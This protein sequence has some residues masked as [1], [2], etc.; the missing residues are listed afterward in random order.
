MTIVGAIMCEL[1][2][3]IFGVLKSG[4]PFD[5]TMHATCAWCEFDPDHLGRAQGACSGQA[6]AAVRAVGGSLRQ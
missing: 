6:V 1:V 3:I 2:H 5:P 4:P